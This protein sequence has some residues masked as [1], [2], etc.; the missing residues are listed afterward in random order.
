[1]KLQ[2]CKRF[3]MVIHLKLILLDKFLTLFTKQLPSQ[4]QQYGRQLVY[5][6]E[7]KTLYVTLH[8]GIIIHTGVKPAHLECRIA[9]PEHKFIAS[10]EK[11]QTLLYVDV[12]KL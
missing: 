7:M 2:W 1:M 10:L 12:T 8:F 11:F 3:I 4:Y 5:Q 9:D 6:N